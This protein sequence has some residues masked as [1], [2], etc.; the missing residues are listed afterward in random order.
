M[1]ESDNVDN[2]QA[3]MF[4]Q[5]LMYVSENATQCT[6][7][8]RTIKTLNL[9]QNRFSTKNAKWT[10]IV[11]GWTQQSKTDSIVQNRPKIYQNLKY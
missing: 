9:W 11:K 8:V 6:T 2:L 3:G 1:K 5:T 10:Y 4:Y 7:E